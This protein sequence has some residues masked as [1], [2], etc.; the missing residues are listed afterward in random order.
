MGFLHQSNLVLLLLEMLR[1]S[2]QISISDTACK[3]FELFAI[4]YRFEA[5]VECCSARGEVDEKMRWERSKE[6]NGEKREKRW[7]QNNWLKC[8][9]RK[10]SQKGIKHQNVRKL[11][12]MK[13]LNTES[14]TG[15]FLKRIPNA[16]FIASLFSSQIEAWRNTIFLHHIPSFWPFNVI[17]KLNIKQTCEAT[18][19]N[20]RES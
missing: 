14:K 16:D 18:C 15:F 4:F 6:K 17:N 19:Y 12:K 7:K 1:F 9:A 8:T 13:L 10:K 2:W 5:F 11:R 20:R 3:N